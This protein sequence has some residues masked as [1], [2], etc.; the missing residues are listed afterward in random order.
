MREKNFISFFLV[1]CCIALWN[2]SFAQDKGKADPIKP[3]Y[4]PTGVIKHMGDIRTY[5]FNE[6]VTVNPVRAPKVNEILSEGFE[7][8]TFPPTGWSAVDNDNDTY[9][10]ERQVGPSFS[11]H[12]GTGCASSAS[13]YNDGSTTGVPL[14]PENWLISPAIDL[15]AV[16][17]A[18]VSWWVVAQD[19][20]YP[21]DK[22]K[23][24][25]STTG[26]SVADFT[27]E[28]FQEVITA[29][30]APGVYLSREVNLT[31][32][33]G[34]TIYL[35]WVHFDCTDQFH[36][37]IDDILVYEPWQTD[38]SVESITSPISGPN[39]TTTEV[40][41][42]VI[43]NNGATEL[44]D[45]EV[46]YTIDGGAAIVET[47]A[48]PIAAG[49]TLEHTF[50]TTAD[51]SV[52]QTYAI[53][54]SVDVAGDQ[55]DTNN[56]KT[57]NVTNQGNIILMQNGSVTT[58][59]G[60][61]Y[62]TG[63]P[64]GMYQNSENLTLTFNPATAGAMMEFVFTE[65]DI[66]NSFEKLYIYNGADDTA[67]Q[68]PGSPFTGLVSPGTITAENPTGAV[69]F[70]FTSDSS[71]PKAGW[72]AT[73]SC[74]IPQASD[75]KV[76]SFT[77][78]TTGQTEQIVTYTLVAK[79]IGTDAILGA[80]YNVELLDADMNVLATL[81]GV[82]LAPLAQASFALNYQL[83]ALGDLVLNGYIN[84]ADDDNMA[85]NT[86]S[87]ITINI[88]PKGLLNETFE[89]LTALPPAGWKIIN[90]GGTNA[91]VL[92]ADN[93]TAGGSKCAA[94]SFQ[95][96]A[97]NDWL[98]TP[99]LKVTAE[100][101]T[102]KYWAKNYSTSYIDLHNLKLSTTGT[103]EADF[104]VTLVANDG[105]PL[106]WKEYI[107]DLSSYIGQDVYIA[108]QAISANMWRLYID[109]V[110]G[111]IINMNE[112]DIE[113]VSI[114]GTSSPVAGTDVTYNVTVKNK[115]L[116]PVLGADYTVS[117]YKAVD[118]DDE[119]LGTL[120]GVNLGYQQT[121]SIPWETNFATEGAMSIYAVVNY[122]DDENLVDNTSPAINI[123]VF[124]E[125]TVFVEVGTG[126]DLS[127][128]MP[129]NFYYKSS[130]SQTIYKGTEI[131]VAGPITHIV[132]KNNFVTN[133]PNKPVKIWMG[134]TDKT[135]L[136]EGWIPSTQLTLVYEGTL[137]F[138]VGVNEIWIELPEV[139]IFE[140]G[141]LAVMALRPM[142]DAYF[143]SNDRFVVTTGTTAFRTR[144]Y[145][146]D[147]AAPTPEAPTGTT[148]ST[149]FPNIK[150]AF[151]MAG[152]GTLAGTITDD[153][154]SLPIAGAKIEIVGST[155]FTLTNENGEF[156]L[157]YLFVGDYSIKISKYGYY[158]ITGDVSIL[159]DETTTFNDS[160]EPLPFVEVSGIV[161]RGDDNMIAVEGATVTLEGYETYTSTTDVDG[162]FL[163]DE[164]YGDKTYTITI[165]NVGFTDYEAEVVVED[166]D[167]DLGTIELF[168]VAYPPI[169]L[170]A[171]INSN[172]EVE[173]AWMQFDPN[174][175][176][177]FRY[178]DGTVSGQLGFTSGT[179][180][181][182]MG[183]VF[184]RNAQILEV[185]W[186]TTSNGGPHTAVNVFI[187]D[188]DGS[189]MPTGNVLY[190]AMG[191]PN[192][193]GVWSTHVLPTPVN[194]PNGFMLAMSYTGFLGLAIDNAT[195]PW[196]FQNNT[197]F[198]NANYTS[199]T[200]SSL[201]SAAFNKNFLLRAVGFDY[202]PLAKSAPASFAT[203]RT[204]GTSEISGSNLPKVIGAGEPNYN[205][206]PSV[207]NNSKV[208][209]SYNVYRAKLFGVMKP[210]IWELVAS[211]VTE[212]SY[213][214]DTWAAQGWGIYKYA[215]KAVYT[216]NN[217]SEPA[218]SGELWK[219]M[220]VP[221]TVNITTNGGDDPEGAIVSFVQSDGNGNH[222]YS[223]TAPTGGVI[224]FENVWRGQYDVTVTHSGHEVLTVS[225]VAF[226]S[227]V[228]SLDVEL[229]ETIVVPYNLTAT[230]EGM[231]AG[232]AQ[233]LW[234]VDNSISDDVEDHADFAVN[235]AAPWTILDVD[236]LATYGANATNFPGESGPIGFIVFNNSTCDPSVATTPEWVAV[237][238]NKYFA[239]IAANSTTVSNND[240][241]ISPELE[242]SN[243]F[244]FR[245]M[246]KSLTDQYGLE[247]FKVGYSTTTAAPAAFT[248]VTAAPYATAPI[249]WTQ[250]SYNIPAD[251]KYVAINCVSLD[252]FIFM[253]DDLYIGPAAKANNSKSF[254][255]YNIYLDG[256]L[257]VSE[258]PETEYEFTGLVAGSYTAGVQSVYTSGT[259]AIVEVGFDVPEA[260]SATFTVTNALTDELLSGAVVTITQG[261]V[262]VVSETT[263][264]VGVASLNLYVGEYEYTVSMMGFALVA[265]EFEIVDQSVEVEV[266]LEPYF[267]L[268]FNVVNENS[269][270]V[271]DA[272]VTLNG[273]AM[274]AGEYVFDVVRGDYS[275]SVQRA[276][277]NTVTGDVTIV[278]EDITVPITLEFT[279]Y[280]VTFNVTSGGVA[281][282][283]A[284]VTFSGVAYEPGVY[285]IA[286]VLPGVYPYTVE[287]EG[288]KTV[289]GNATV[290]A[291][292]ITVPVN[293]L[294]YYDVTFTVQ[295][296]SAEPIE[297]AE[298]AIV[299]V[300]GSLTTGIDGVAST[301][302]TNGAYSYSVTFA[303]YNAY[304]GSF[305][306]NNA[307]ANVNVTLIHVGIEDGFIS[308]VSLYPN[309]FNS[310]FTITNATNVKRMVVTNLIG[311]VIMDVEM[312]GE[313]TRNIETANLPA[314]VYL[315]K[316]QGVL[317]QES[318][319]KMVKK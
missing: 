132:Y 18:Y 81:P 225:S 78:P 290:V 75:L 142:D 244:V 41:T 89:G 44:S 101:H 202:G 55:D 30:K 226:T 177:E 299:G 183:S 302:L 284:I 253:V 52:V 166:L 250:F 17:A 316:L 264:A 98:I 60:T 35:A 170:T 287:K 10:W 300:A 189:G 26:Y 288:Y 90:G 283:E 163:F 118:G 301:Q 38:A 14:T 85:N 157:P 153:V 123:T 71:V 3:T 151:N 136:T 224:Y 248:F 13:W 208:F 311:Q 109:D 165:S 278:D 262:E 161:V 7:S 64:G 193:D 65:F 258:H 100:Y 76:V 121:V 93:H 188:L 271:S 131:G 162:N 125:S 187:L 117:I 36:M 312:N 107:V 29:S 83:V 198:Y 309:P 156:T 2:V 304:T 234:N 77:G 297:G 130:L 178:D 20:A 207:A 5:Q 259:S 173:L 108:F 212:L 293:M 21:A 273:V 48:G 255:G 179:A 144:T 181:G 39:L 176:T 168:E 140:G 236:G 214:D 263:D 192:T 298:I 223:L 122:V 53:V 84:F 305:S 233:L 292:N 12:S 227:D 296:S 261:G 196:V 11:V 315:I 171:T 286:N 99:Q 249:G 63:G 306:V 303:D 16:S 58:C 269:D 280:T 291:A 148:N 23:L 34:E 141:N 119:L 115:G 239:S 205:N 87:T 213:I 47:I 310:N 246:A 274:A 114:A 199:G 317:G 15:T 154:T 204:S 66:E 238:G 281:L 88:V 217:L 197:H 219:D 277:Y 252:A 97:H 69:T 126:A 254:L 294:M 169:N 265:G 24:V 247:R 133:L 201:E 241:L 42:A 91:W 79:N 62:D 289:S 32:Y 102:F 95:T 137:N 285:V 251:A 172:D 206:K 96:A 275:Y 222:T 6:Q 72:A 175:Q 318:V 54:V 45:L 266:E 190:Q 9:N 57:V 272:V 103:E 135:D 180:Q 237:S 150:M 282:P 215:V 19:A 229:I 146:S 268:T 232:S 86:S 221:V 295:N 59:S 257:V 27:V 113:A 80:N 200:F 8:T 279:R 61:F 68:F 106:A 74:F 186:Q 319:R 191:V 164:V 4:L 134:N 149:L 314:G 235:D 120:S 139:F 307:N 143:N 67:P 112:K 73:V 46:S 242:F 245:F 160:M 159:E 231:P 145:S 56:S 104:T 116:E 308:N 147:T 40:V 182:V 37:N 210:D 218:I 110:S 70:K 94:I 260:Y 203:T 209:E 43:K 155:R 127:N 152:M 28:L 49:A 25:L 195:D 194:A 267:T 105:P 22:Y 51:L 50:A 230:T 92:Y 185:T 240:W 33:I 220:F 184:R 82:D 124:N 129:W 138:P 313:V 228:N 111:L 256:G 1:L 276:T 216:N 174:A 31:P 270:P 158:D 167:V 211:D 128:A 243:P